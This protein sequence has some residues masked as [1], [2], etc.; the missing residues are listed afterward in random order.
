MICTVMIF[1]RLS[2][3]RFVNFNYCYSFL[4]CSQVLTSKFGK[5]KKLS[6]HF[7]SYNIDKKETN[8]AEGRF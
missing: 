3:G 8:L 5:H 6:Y 7:L 2:T 4:K 1:P